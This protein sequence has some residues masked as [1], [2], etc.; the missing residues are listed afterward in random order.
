VKIIVPYQIAPEIEPHLPAECTVVHIDEHG[1][2]DGDLRDAVVFLRWWTPRKVY[3]QV[4]A[5]APAVRWIHTP[6]AGVD[7]VLIPQVIESDIVLTNS[8]GA[9]AV[10]IAEF[11]LLFVLGHAKNV[12]YFARFQASEW[13]TGHDMPLQ[14]LPNKTILI[15]GLGAI[16]QEVAVRAAAFGMRVLGSRRTPRPTA[17]V[18]QVVGEDAWR[19]LLPAADFIVVATPHTPATHGMVNAAAFAQMKPSA[20]L[21]NIARGDIIDEHALLAA[22]RQGQIAGAALDTPPQEP[23]PPE[24]PL[25]RE[26]NCWITPHISWS[27]PLTMERAKGFFFENLR[28]FRA[29]EPLINIVD[30]DAGY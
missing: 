13:E 6:S 20:Y 23:L 3:A 17:G 14:E 22:L 28:R 1:N 30:K 5:A 26:P 16:G 9:H 25:W 19:A 4:L 18:D 12:R 11:V 2:A 29:G 10:P 7:G 15:L 8:A 24:H 27:S 21:I